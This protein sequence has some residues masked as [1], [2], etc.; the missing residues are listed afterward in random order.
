MSIYSKFLELASGAARTVDLSTNTLSVG[1]VQLNGSTSGTL[2]HLANATTSTYTLTWPAA[3]AAS[4]G[5]L[6]SSTT[7]GVLSWVVAPTN[8]I[9]QLTGDVTAG[10]GSGSQVASL[11]ATSNATLA[12]LSALT[13]ASA[14]STVGTITSGTWN[15]SAIGPTYGGTGLTAY[16]TGDILYASATNTLSRLPIGT[17]GYVLSVVSG[18]PA[19]SPAAATGANTALSNLVGVAINTSL[20]PGVDDTINLGSPTFS[21]ASANIHTLE[22]ASGVI[23]VDAYNRLLDDASGNTQLTWST[24]GVQIGT[25]GVAGGVLSVAGPSSGIY[26]SISGQYATS[27][28]NFN[29][30]QTAGTSGQVLASG[31]GGLNRMNWVNA[32][33]G[34]VTS[35]SVVSANG[36]AGTVATS[37]TT[38][39]ITISTT[40]TAPVLAANGTAIIAA[41]TTGTGST[42]VL[43]ASP[44]LTGTLTAAAVSLS[45]ALNMNSNEINGLAMAGS[46]AGTD[47]TNVTYVQAQISAAISG[48]TWK[49]PVNAYANSNIALTGGAT[50]TIDGYSVQNGN[51]VILGNQTTASQNNVYLVSGIGTAYSLTVA[52]GS[53][54][55]TALGDAYL[56][57]D[58]TVYGNSAF[59]V[60]QLT[61]NITFIQFA[62]PNTYTF[63]E[64]LSVSG[65]TVSLGYDNSTIGLNGSNQLIVKTAGI[66]A[67]Q[68]ANNAVGYAQFQE[69]AA[70]SLVGNPTGSLANAE[71]ITLGTGL[72]F[73]GTT[74]NVASTPGMT[75]TATYGGATTLTANT[76]YAFRWGMPANSETAD[77]LYVADWS[78]SSFDLFWVV[79]L[80]NSAS[81]TPTN[82]VITITTQ[83]SLTLGSSDTAFGSSD[84]GRPVWLGSSGAFTPNSTFAPAT[85]DA[86]FKLGIAS[87]ASTIWID[88]QMM[89]V[90]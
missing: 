63:N 60:N 47:A 31:G 17:N 44:T 11:V 65:N 57:L 20:L 24:S 5:Y 45:G 59:Q 78:T 83:G 13:T 25:A 53:E 69:V 74:L 35:T 86:N 36:F 26:V 80:Y 23:S 75:L 72:S 67:T 87:S 43:S 49:G 7:A 2:T 90:S 81:S 50:L 71:G 30:P 32:A 88:G 77:K 64:P 3:A 29:L 4:N 27:S 52:T 8:G 62:G 42:V 55:A 89:G 14:L 66:T 61:P 58:G 18:I 54:A 9:T 48:L 15:G 33:T 16:T 56:I 10:P 82:T 85:G 21:W 12:T 68:I 40:V 73:T 34:T 46:P 38:P 28:W 79:G 51:Y 76:T 22:D 70:G 84:Q 6:L 37:T 19:W 1:A 41:T 39:A